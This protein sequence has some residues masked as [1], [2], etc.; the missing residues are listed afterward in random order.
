MARSVQPIR[1]RVAVI[2]GDPAGVGPELAAKLLSNQKNLAKADIHVLADNSEWESAIADAGN[3]HVPISDTASPNG[4]KIHDDNSASQVS[5]VRAEVSQDGGARCIYQLKRALRMVEAGE[6]DAI[7]FAP[8]NKS[9]LKKAGMT[10][11][12]ELRW[13]ANQLQYSGTTSEINIAGP[14]WTARVTS[15][16]G[17]EE[18]AARVSKE[19]TLKAIELLQQ[20]RWES[21][22][23]YPRLAVC[24]LNPHNGENGSFGR[25]EIDHIRPA[26]LAAREKGIDVEGPFPC[27]TIFLKRAHYDGIVTMY[28][29]QGQIALKLL[30]FDGGVTVQ[31]GLPIPIATP[32]HGTAF[33]IA[34]KNLASVTSTQNA[35]D[36]AVTMAERRIAKQLAG[37]T[38]VEV[39]SPKQRILPQITT[40]EVPSC[41]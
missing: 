20:L 12:D 7:V 2:L 30:S 31:G 25:Q 27:D 6:I 24:A 41:C 18:V 15:H 4:V 40:K 33:D 26:V 16:I 10:E 3:V 5:V 29:D 35:F 37:K 38:A 11:E 14:L 8:L 22:I 34:G 32:A 13:F 9:S 36:V 21:G 19:S 28:H 23:E 1:P 17:I 39:I